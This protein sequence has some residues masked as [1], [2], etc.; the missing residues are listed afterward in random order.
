M[1]HTTQASQSKAAVMTDTYIS[2][3]CCVPESWL[4]TSRLMLYGVGLGG[5]TVIR[6]TGV[7]LIK[8]K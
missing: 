2:E 7:Y 4:P 1:T 5:S 3:S 8:K 6:C